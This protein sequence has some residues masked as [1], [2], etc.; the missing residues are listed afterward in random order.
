MLLSQCVF[1]IMLTCQDRIL[2]YMNFYFCRIFY[3]VCF[4]SINLVNITEV[5]IIPLIAEALLSNWGS[6]PT[7]GSL[8]LL[9]PRETLG[10]MLSW[11]AV[12]ILRVEQRIHFSPLCSLATIPC[13]HFPS[14]AVLCSETLSVT[15][16][17]HFRNILRKSPSW[18]LLLP[19]FCFRNSIFQQLFS[20]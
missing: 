13:V 3:V 9:V 10:P 15:A 20:G 16:R 1:W 18:L 17:L 11:L 6:A 8:I 19:L 12:Q 4:L 2:L 7:V 5:G 14:Q